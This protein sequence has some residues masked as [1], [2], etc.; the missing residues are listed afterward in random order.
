MT[1]FSKLREG[2]S[3]VWPTSSPQRLGDQE[4][5][6][7]ALE[8]FRAA[9]LGLL[10][11][12]AGDRAAMLNLRIRCAATLQSLWFMRSEM[13]AIL[14]TK[15]GEVEARHRLDMISELVRDSL[16]SGLRSRPSPLGRDS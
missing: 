8:K 10:D 5:E 9:M 13:M 16:P 1:L 3:S 15:H 6:A 14:A 7:A 4:A 2:I 11:G 12:D